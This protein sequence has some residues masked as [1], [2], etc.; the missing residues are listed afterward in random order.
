MFGALRLDYDLFGNAS[1]A[2]TDVLIGDSDSY[3]NSSN[4]NGK[5]EVNFTYLA[6]EMVEKVLQALTLSH[7]FIRGNRSAIPDL[8]LLEA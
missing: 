6:T 5:K 2:E 8:C 3:I 7:L 4:Y 1:E